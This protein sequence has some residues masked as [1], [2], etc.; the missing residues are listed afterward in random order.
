MVLP[1]PE[2]FS[3]IIFGGGSGNTLKIAMATK[4]LDAF[5]QRIR[6]ITRC[7]GGRSLQQVAEQLSLYM[8]GWKSLVAS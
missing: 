4:A 5:K 8:P 7:L 2:S 6:E 1:L 3:A